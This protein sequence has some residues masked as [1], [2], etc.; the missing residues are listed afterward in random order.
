MRL[1]S[2]WRV[3]RFF[4]FFNSVAMYASPPIGAHDAMK[5]VPLGCYP[6]IMVLGTALLVVAPLRPTVTSAQI[7]PS[8][9]KHLSFVGQ[10]TQDEEGKDIVYPSFLWMDSYR[11]EIYVIEGKG[12]VLVFNEKLFPLFTLG[13]GHGIES[14]QG[15]M[16]DAGGYL[17][18][19]E[20]PV[21]N[22][23][24]GRIALF[25][26]CLNWKKDI[27]FSGFPGADEFTPYRLAENSRGE[28]FVVGTYNPTVVVLD[29]FGNLTG[30]FYHEVETEGVKRHVGLN[31]VIVGPDDRLYLLSEETSHVYVY[32]ADRHF[33]FE[34][35]QKGGSTGK[36][37]RPQ[38]IAFD[39]QSGYFFIVDYMR[40][41][42]TIYDGKGQFIFE[43]GGLGW[44]EGWFQY[45]KDIV[46]DW[47][48]RIL[49]ADTFNNRIQVFQW[50][51]EGP[52]EGIA[53]SAAPA[54]QEEP[55][56]EPG[57]E[58]EVPSIRAVPRSK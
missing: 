48:R 37:S 46:V 3:L 23:P 52:P 26:R 39:P 38:G 58:R 12:Q 43:F 50:K 34:F 10:I 47:S 31:D 56:T 8:L 35:G 51:D 45:P 21:Q 33:L 41:G 42:V 27:Y 36:M 28:V 13:K 5:R 55:V 57:P 53:P 9:E 19:A 2:A 30:V 49:V 15:L 54:A 16:V 44:G 14:A 4:P 40:H 24:R 29:T 20:A 11:K 22:N 25:D 18:V 7:A 32:D 17:W 6:L 1:C